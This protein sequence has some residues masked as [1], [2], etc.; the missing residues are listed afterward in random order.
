MTQL[1]VLDLETTGFNASRH[2][3]VIEVAIVQLDETLTPTWEYCSLVNPDRDLGPTHVHGLAGRDVREA[4]PFVEV[5]DDIVHWLAG[6]V[7]VGHNVA[8]DLRFLRAEF[9]LLGCSSTSRTSAER[10]SAFG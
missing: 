5:A 6:R 9:D 3:R 2:D 8:F 1:A 7:I 4:P 10:A